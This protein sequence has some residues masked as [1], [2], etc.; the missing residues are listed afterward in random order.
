MNVYK[1]YNEEGWSQMKKTQDAILFEDLRPVTKNY[2]YF[3]FINDFLP[4]K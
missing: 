4:E 3:E 1:F 2:V